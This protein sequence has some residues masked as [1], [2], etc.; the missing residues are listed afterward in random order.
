MLL[1]TNYG[2]LQENPF[3]WMLDGL[4]VS[5]GGNWDDVVNELLFIQL[6]FARSADP[7]RASDT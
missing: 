6:V 3:G 1:P 4:P 2:P 5:G 7:L